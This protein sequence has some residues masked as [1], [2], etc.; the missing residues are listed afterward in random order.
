VD[1][2]DESQ[3]SSPENRYHNRGCMI[4]RAER[5]GGLSISRTI[6]WLSAIAVLGASIVACAGPGGEKDVDDYSGAAGVLTDTS[7][8]ADIV[9][10]VA[11]DRLTVS[12]LIPVGSDPH[13]F[14]PTPKDAQRV[15]GC[16]AM[17]VNVVGL[18]PAIDDLVAGAGGADKL[19]IEAAAGIPD[20]DK[21]PHCW[22][23]PVL[24]VAYL[25]NI[26]E[27]LAKVD[28][29]GAASYRTNA[30]AYSETLRELDS[31]VQA[32]VQTI[33]AERRL[34]VTN[35]E[36]LGRFAARYGFEIVG[37]IFPTPTGE[38]SPSARG[39][40]QL[41]ADIRATGAPAIFVETGSNSGLADQVAA[42]TGLTVVTDLY[43]HSLG[44][45]ASSYVE[46]MRWNVAKIVEAL[47]VGVGSGK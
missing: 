26:A 12:S 6:G 14:E 37:A 10:N 42:E 27:G 17:V 40:A 30:E 1:A 23:D 4:V 20:L 43:T 25:D 9:Q 18:L 31:W 36:S 15:A 44:K 46:M 41:V 38:G 32:Q 2:T 28:P 24:V 29:Q 11:G 7:F 45:G 16:L 35:H 19:V 34:L 13:S 39:L 5:R 3:C 47:A 21:D 8:L 22:L 33:P